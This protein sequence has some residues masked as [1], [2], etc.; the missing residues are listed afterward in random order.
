MAEFKGDP[1]LLG[2]VSPLNC[3]SESWGNCRLIC[4]RDI[5][6]FLKICWQ[7]VLLCFSFAGLGRL[8][9]GPNT[10]RVLNGLSEVCNYQVKPRK[11]AIC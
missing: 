11:T 10:F 4:N 5:L 8:L 3:G 9:F 7:L 1:S 2:K 6:E